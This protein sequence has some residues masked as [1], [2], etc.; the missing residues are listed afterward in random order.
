MLNTFTP[1]RIWLKPN[2]FGDPYEKL[3]SDRDVLFL[4]TVA[5][6]F[7]GS[8]IPTSGL[9]TIPQGPF[10]PNLVPIGR[11]VSEEKSFEKL[12]TTTDT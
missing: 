9:C 10:I 7:D 2:G 8:Q 3:L 1:V 6:F 5:M 4:V 11:V 12:L